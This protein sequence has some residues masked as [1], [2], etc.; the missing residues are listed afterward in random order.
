[1]RFWLDRGIDGIRIDVAHAMVKDRDLRDD[2]APG[3]SP[4]SPSSAEATYAWDQPDVHEIHRA[5]RRLADSYGDRVLVGE[6]WLD[7]ADRIAR[8]VRP[9][10]LHLAFSFA[11][12]FAPWGRGL[13]DA[14]QASLASVD[15][16]GARAT[17]VLS[18]HDVPRVATRYGG[19]P[20]GVRRARAAALLQLGLPGAVFVYQGDE[21]GLEDVDLPAVV[22]QDPAEG[23]ADASQPGRDGCR[24]PIP[25]DGAGPGFGFTGGTSWL[26]MP[27][28]W[29]ELSVQRQQ[30]DEASVR[31]LYQRALAVRRARPALGDGRLEWLV[32]RDDVL[33][34]RVVS[35]GD[36]V[37]VA[38]NTGES[39]VDIDGVADVLVASGP[40]RRT[41]RGRLTL[42]TDTAAWL[43]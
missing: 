43:G 18:N 20:L 19:G 29:G 2:A 30:A 28:S 27:A 15:A 8:Y 38:V 21:L 10:E 35:G 40:V 39:D 36:V 32:A 3:S 25:W 13:R 31:S 34:W 17:W 33:V 26:P 6:V 5:W 7:D 42:P 22:R 37:T 14:V 11:L 9:D 23:Q 4:W 12:L 24:V 41:A 16:V 1:M